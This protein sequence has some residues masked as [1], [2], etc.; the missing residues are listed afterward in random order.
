MAIGYSGCNP[1]PRPLAGWESRSMRKIHYAGGA[2]TVDDQTCKAIL[3]YARALAKADKADLVVMRGLTDAG[4]VGIAHVLIGPSSQI[5][6]VPVDELDLELGDP[7]MVEILEGRT[8]QLDPKTPDW[9]NDV[10]DVSDFT[11]FDWD[12]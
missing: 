7:A 11:S 10:L 2:I 3:R 6:S 1:F 9:N 12:F 5:L 4:K 8:R